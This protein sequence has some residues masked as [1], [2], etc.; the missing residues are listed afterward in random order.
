MERFDV[1]NRSNAE[2][3]DRIYEQ[4]RRE[5]RS[6]DESWRAFFAVVEFVA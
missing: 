1:V 3:I 5:A 2:Y 6:V 4:Y